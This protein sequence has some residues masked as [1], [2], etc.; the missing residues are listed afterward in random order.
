VEIVVQTYKRVTKRLLVWGLAGATVL[1]FAG[2]C[3]SP[4]KYKD[5]ADTE[6]YQIIQDKWQNNFG[7]MANYKVTEANETTSVTDMVPASGVLT[8]AEAVEIA[9]KHSREYQTQKESL[10]L[11]ALN[12]TGSRHQYARQWFGTIDGTYYTSGGIEDNTAS[13]SVGV[14]QSHLIGDGIQIGTGL[15]VDWVR[16]LS[17]DPHTTLAS[18]LTAT[19]AAP[20]LGAG[21]GK[22]AR[23]NLTQ[24]ERDVLYRIRSFNR[25]RKTFVTS[26]I[27]DYYQVLQQK[28]A[29]AVTEAS[30]QRQVISTNQ[31]RMEVDVGQRPQSDADEAEQRLLSVRNSLVSTRQSYEQALDRFKIRLAL[32]TDAEVVLDQNELTALEDVGVSEPDYSVEQAIDMAIT[33]RL[34][35]ANTRDSLDDS[36]RKLILAA[37][38]LGPQL[39]L[40]GSANVDSTPETQWTRLQ[41]HEGTYSLGL[42]ADLPFDRLSERNAYRRALITVQQ[43]QRDYEQDIE[44]TKLDVRQAYRDLAETAESYK[45]QKLGLQLAE[46]RVE[47]Q[48]LLL[49]YSRGTVRLLLDSEDALVEAK[50][51]VTDALVRHTNAKL[52]FF[53]DIG[54]LQVRPDGMWE[55]AIP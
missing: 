25:Y 17:G 14:N 18:V 26:I 47:E 5:Q 12:L 42:E 39:N 8:L 31:L 30:Y 35:L 29:V 21:A 28:D 22:T 20:L 50:N 2:A 6:V 55:Q 3:K 1:G 19:V 11:S 10:Y 16:F 33:R 49:E 9:T 41:F 54:I 7:E 36:E 24:D 44:Q 37:E 43:R 38:G 13:S 46:R 53:R 32:P 51:R 15:A 23:E 48:K 52:N 27:N 4:A 45:I 40:V 34:D